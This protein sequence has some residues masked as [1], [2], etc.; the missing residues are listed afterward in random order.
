MTSKKAPIVSVILPVYNAELYLKEAI[1]SILNQTF[2]DFECIII[3]DGSTDGSKAII[4]SYGDERIIFVDQANMGL[5]ATLNKGIRLARG[6]YIARQDNDD[7]SL[8]TRLQEQVKYLEDHPAVALLGTHALIIDENG[9]STGRSLQPPTASYQVKFYLLFGNPFAHSSVFLRR[10]VLDARGLYSQGTSYFEDHN[11][12]SRIARIADVANLPEQLIKYREVPSSM[13]RSTA[14]YMQRVTRQTL[15]NIKH[16]APEMPD[17]MIRE[18]V[19]YINGTVYPANFHQAL[20]L[21]KKFLKQLTKSFARKE[22]ISIKLAE[23]EGLKQLVHF[24]RQFYNH[25]IHSDSESLFS[26]L[27][28]RARRKFMFARYGK[29]LF[30]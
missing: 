5:A 12:W 9:R 4:E 28:A 21:I 14:D 19:T 30:R 29:I 24:K 27:G 6:K 15:E 8:H 17:E 22:K 18:C 11:L 7:V 20:L 16:Y 3:N 13:S 26:K 25:V 23:K 10:S 2:K 1:G